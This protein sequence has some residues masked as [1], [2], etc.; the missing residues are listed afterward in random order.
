MMRKDPEAV[1]QWS[2]ALVE[3][4]AKRQREIISN[5]WSALKPGGYFVYSTCTFNRTEN[6]DMVRWIIDE[7][8]AEPVEIP[9]EASWGISPGINV[10]F[11]CYKPCSKTVTH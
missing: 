5:L 2:P 7:Y 1:A 9:A 11:P 10:D 4:C 8:D 6:E 3:S